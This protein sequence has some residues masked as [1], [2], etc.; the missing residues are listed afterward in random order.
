MGLFK[1]SIKKLL[2]NKDVPGLTKALEHSD[3]KVRRDAVLALGSLR[4][5]QA[6]ESLLVALKDADVEVGVAAAVALGQIGDVRAVDQRA[7]RQTAGA[8]ISD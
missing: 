3:W 7:T 1:P 4:E 2:K 8:P 6:V 5:V